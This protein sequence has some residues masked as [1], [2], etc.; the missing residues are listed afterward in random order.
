M[1]MKDDI[2]LLVDTREYN[3]DAIKALSRL[4]GLDMDS[5]GGL[6]SD[7]INHPDGIT[8]WLLAENFILK[9]QY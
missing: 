8:E 4:S 6:L 7:L 9:N 1:S 5:A 2:Q 3:W